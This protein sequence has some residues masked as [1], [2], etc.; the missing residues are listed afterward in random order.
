MATS[1]RNFLKSG[2]LGLICA[3]LPAALAKVALGSPE[4]AGEFSDG[5]ATSLFNF[6]QA[7]FKPYINTKFKIKTGSAAFDLRLTKITDLKA[8]S[9]I[10]AR[11]AGKESFSLLFAGSRDAARLTQ[12]TY[13]LEH[14]ALGTF[15]LFLV[16]IGE[17]KNRHHEAI[18]IRL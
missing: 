5:N 7:A 17:A 12:D 3:G 16:P 18:I 15:S 1:R 2:T 4:I 14:A 9:K 10:P 13:T 6:T 8:I 11:I